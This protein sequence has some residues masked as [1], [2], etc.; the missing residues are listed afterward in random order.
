MCEYSSAKC[1]FDQQKTC[2]FSADVFESQRRDLFKS[3]VCSF[4]ILV[5]LTRITTCFCCL[6]CN[7][8]HTEIWKT[9][10]IISGHLIGKKCVII[11]QLYS[12]LNNKLKKHKNSRPTI[13]SSII[14]GMWKYV[15]ACQFNRRKVFLFFSLKNCRIYNDLLMLSFYLEKEFILAFHNSRHF[16]SG[17]WP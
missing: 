11:I 15:F 2:R 5:C 17:L 16:R 4:N 13:C 7:N 1:L 8:D 9:C 14:S 10:R 12:S 3:H 6:L